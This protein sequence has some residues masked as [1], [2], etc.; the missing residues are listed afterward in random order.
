MVNHTFLPGHRIM[1]QV[2]STLFP[3]YDRN[4]QTYVPNIFDAKPQTIRK[5]RSAS[6]TPRAGQLHQPS[7]RANHGTLIHR[8]PEIEST[9]KRIALIAALPSEL[10][11][12]IHHWTHHAHLSTGR[13][14]S[15]EVVAACSGMG[16]KAVTRACERALSAG[17]VDTLVS[18]GYAGS[19]SCGLR[20]PEAVP[21]REV[22]DGR[23][24][25]ASQPI[26]SRTRSKISP[27]VSASSPSTTLP[28]PKKSAAWPK[29][30]RPSWSTWKPQP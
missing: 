21:V 25:E 2:Q 23:T 11:P 7:R 18:V 10:K 24:G 1:V 30:I 8:P 4:P 28:D 5:P 14:G 13:I 16:E 6:G 20:A 9:M 19:L 3:L 17:N 27:K 22:I 26:N 15:L 29:P 12:L